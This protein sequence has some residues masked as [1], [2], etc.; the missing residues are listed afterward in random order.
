[1]G[2]WNSFQKIRFGN[3]LFQKTGP[4]YSRSAERPRALETADILQFHCSALLLCNQWCCSLAS[5][6]PKAL[7]AFFVLPFE[8]QIRWRLGPK[9]YHKPALPEYTLTKWSVAVFLRKFR[10][11]QVFPGRLPPAHKEEM[12]DPESCRIGCSYQAVDEHGKWHPAMPD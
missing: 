1:M 12:V 10:V 7:V 3:T 5:A 9:E 2:T 6:W 11:I 8:V 4:L